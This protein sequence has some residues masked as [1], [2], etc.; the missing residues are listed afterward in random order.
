MVYGCILQILLG[1]SWIPWP[2]QRPGRTVK[3]QKVTFFC[4]CFVSNGNLVT[5]S[6]FMRWKRLP[7]KNQNQTLLKVE[8]VNEEY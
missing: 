4:S 3:C 5:G 8:D 1:H 2:T 6:K 7:Y